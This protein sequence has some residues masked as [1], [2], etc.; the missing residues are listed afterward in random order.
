MLH[1]RRDTGDVVFAANGK[2]INHPDDAGQILRSLKG[3]IILTIRKRQEEKGPKK[4]R[5]GGLI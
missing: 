3:Q 2:V 5:F 4:K 1:R